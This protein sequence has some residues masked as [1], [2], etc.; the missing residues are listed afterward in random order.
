MQYL[1]TTTS[2]CI[3][4][5]CLSGVSSVKLTRKEKRI[6]VITSIFCISTFILT[7]SITTIVLLRSMSALT[8]T[9]WWILLR[10]KMLMWN[11]CIQLSGRRQTSLLRRGWINILRLRLCL[12]I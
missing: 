7:S 1:K 3:M 4:M 10:I 12:I 9:L 2:K 11:F 6:L 5:T 8:Q